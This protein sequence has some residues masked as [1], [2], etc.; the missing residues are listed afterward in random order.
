M[1]ST[2]FAPDGLEPLGH[3]LAQQESALPSVGYH[4]L[5]APG[6][7]SRAAR[8]V[9]RV[10]SI[11]RALGCNIFLRDEVHTVTQWGHEPNTR[12]AIKPG[13]CRVAVGAVDV[14]YRRPVSLTIR[15]VDAPRG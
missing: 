3:V 2:A 14:T 5:K 11:R 6:T 10:A 15:T 7:A 8:G 9:Q 13:K 12:S 4:S 1:R